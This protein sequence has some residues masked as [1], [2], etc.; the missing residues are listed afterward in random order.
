MTQEKVERR[1]E[2]IKM[3]DD[4]CAGKITR[5]EW[6]LYI[7]D[8]LKYFCVYYLNSKHRNYWGEKEDLMQ[9]AYTAI[10]ANIDKYNPR[11]ATPST[12]FENYIN[13]DTK[14]ALT[15][16]DTLTSYYLKVV[17]RLEKRARDNGFDGMLDDRLTADTLAV[18]SE[19]PIKTVIEAIKFKSMTH[20]S[21][22][23]FENCVS[24]SSGNR[25]YSKSPE[26]LLIEKEEH[27]FIQEQ[28]NKCTSLERFLIEN[29]TMKENPVSYRSLV[30]NF[31]KPEFKAMFDEALPEKIDQVYLEQKHNHALRRIRYS[32]N[33]T[34]Y[35]EP[36][37]S[38]DVELL[39]IEDTES[40]ICEGVFDFEE[41]HD[42]QLIKEAFATQKIS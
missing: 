42:A 22:D 4:Y 16:N 17:T 20:I 38:E 6:I 30:I 39:S 15:S 13:D 40:A 26:E 10:I 1:E 19:T 14:K 8:L 12:F 34:R 11:I 27:A 29:I 25:E 2:T 18:I 3:Y 28:L 32:R 35:F 36:N 41:G 24:D 31:K 5:D 9:Q 21:Y 37:D 7:I 33:T 23:N